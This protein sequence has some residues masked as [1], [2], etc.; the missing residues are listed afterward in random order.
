[1]ERNVSSAPPSGLAYRRGGFLRTN[2]CDRMISPSVPS[3][4]IHTFFLLCDMPRGMRCTCAAE[5]PM[6]VQPYQRR[7]L[8]APGHHGIPFLHA[9]MDRH[10]R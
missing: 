1:M 7:R 9:R 6:P 5:Q 10:Y 3:G 8:R 4:P 2:E